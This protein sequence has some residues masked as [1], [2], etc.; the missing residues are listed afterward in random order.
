MLGGGEGRRREERRREEGGV[1]KDKSVP[2][3]RCGF[4]SSMSN[5]LF[6][7]QFIVSIFVI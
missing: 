1:L 5:D 2:H 7:N 6:I 4:C 3:I